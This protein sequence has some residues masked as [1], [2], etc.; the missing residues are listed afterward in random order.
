[1]EILDKSIFLKSKS[2]FEGGEKQYLLASGNF[3]ELR[4]ILNK[5]EFSEN[6]INYQLNE[7]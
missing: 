6:V 5:V 3:K 2:S 7:W 1:M 4:K